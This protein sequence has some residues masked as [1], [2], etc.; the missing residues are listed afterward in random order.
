MD[1]PVLRT[2]RCHTKLWVCITDSPLQTASIIW[3][4]NNSGSVLRM[5]CCAIALVNVTKS[6]LYTQCRVCADNEVLRHNMG[7]YIAEAQQAKRALQSSRRSLRSST[8]AAETSADEAS[9]A[10]ILATLERPPSSHA[11]K[12]DIMAPV[13]SH[14][15]NA[16]DH[17]PQLPASASSADAGVAGAGVTGASGLEPRQQASAR[18]GGNSSHGGTSG[19]KLAFQP[20]QPLQPTQMQSGPRGP[21]HS[22]GRAAAGRPQQGRRSRCKLPPRSR[23]PVPS[24]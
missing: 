20:L 3:M 21:R 5:R 17:R 16:R 15:V 2:T 7:V 23:L 8:P 10:A 22:L 14:T 9:A 1:S 6:P 19:M 12:D 24:V 18:A 11:A 4:G 13:G